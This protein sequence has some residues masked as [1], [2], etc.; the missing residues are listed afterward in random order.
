[1]AAFAFSRGVMKRVICILLMGATSALAQVSGFAPL[2]QPEVSR[3]VSKAKDGHTESQLR[4]GM[5][6]EYGL[7]V[8]VDLQ[9]AEYWLKTA[10]GFG[11]AEAQ[12]QLGLLYLQPQFTQSRAQALRWFQLASANGSGRAE[13]N[14]G[15]MY[16]LGIGVAVN[17]DE[18]IRWFRRASSHGLGASKANLGVLLVTRPDPGDQAEGFSIVSAAAKHGDTDAENALGYCY[19]YGA[20]THV[21]LRKAVEWYKR[22][23]AHGNLMAMKNI[24]DMYRV[25]VGVP[26]DPVEA[27]HWSDE[28]CTSGEWRACI[29][30]ANAY[31]HGEGTSPNDEKAYQFALM[32]GVEH[33]DLEQLESRLP[34]EARA[35]AAREAEHWKQA[36]AVRL[37]ALPH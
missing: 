15:L 24:S 19:Q 26:R 32:A 11:D 36:H 35:Q 28:A 27:F 37:S 31:L 33:R 25:G 16:T 21:D 30:V 18:A 12:T 29:S 8:N 20:G 1:M 4:L 17:R 10:A 5:A 22:A 14:L 23:A 13:H 9:T 2:S 7:G 34:E 3:L 6:Y